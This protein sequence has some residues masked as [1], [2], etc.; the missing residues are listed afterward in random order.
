MNTSTHETLAE[1][2]DFVAHQAEEDAGLPSGE[3]RHQADLV[4]DVLAQE[5]IEPTVRNA[6][7]HEYIESVAS[8]LTLAA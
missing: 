3:R 1:L 7:V 5:P 4:K 2:R 6:L 8:H